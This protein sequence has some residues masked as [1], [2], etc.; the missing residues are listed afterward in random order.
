MVLY[1]GGVGA[2]MTLASSLNRVYSPKGFGL[3]KSLALLTTLILLPI[4][5][6]TSKRGTDPLLNLRG[7]R[8]RL[9]NECFGVGLFLDEAVEKY[10][11]IYNKSLP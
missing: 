9:I 10:K 1:F 8:R 6:R 3:E 7:K 2:R 4:M 5:S 11:H